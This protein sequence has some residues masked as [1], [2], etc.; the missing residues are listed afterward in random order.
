MAQKSSISQSIW[1]VA[2]TLAGLGVFYRIPEVMPRIEQIEQFSSASGIIR[3]CFYVMGILLVAG[4][5]KKIYDNYQGMT[6]DNN[7]E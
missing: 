5:G 6:S 4:G 2:L 3:F 1:G 7:S